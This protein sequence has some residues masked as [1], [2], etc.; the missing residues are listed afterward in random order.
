MMA[1]TNDTQSSSMNISMSKLLSGLS[2]K[3]MRKLMALAAKSGKPSG[4]PAAEKRWFDLKLCGLNKDALKR[5]YEVRLELASPMTSSHIDRKWLRYAEAFKKMP[6]KVPALFRKGIDARQLYRHLVKF[7]HEHDLPDEIIAAVVPELIHYINTGRMRPVIFVGERGCGKTTAV[8]LIMQEALH[9]PV[10][11]IKVPE[12]DRSHGLT[13]D[14]GSYK[15][16]DLGY[17]AKAQLRSNSLIVG[18]VIDEIDKVPLD[19]TSS[20][21]DDELLSVT[22]D[23]V[24][25]IEDKYL[26][27]T[28]PSLPYC[29]IF[30][31]GNDL[32]QI[33]PILADRC[34]VI[35]YP[36]A[37]PER[38]KAIMRKYVDKKLHEGTYRM[39]DLDHDMLCRSIDTLV[40]FKV[41]SL[42][43]HQEMIE[44]VLNQ[45][46][47]KAMTT[48]DDRVS[49]TPEMF[50]EA[51]QKIL[52]TASRKCGFA[53]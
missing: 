33:N 38:I 22:D 31:T 11:I 24:D 34:K 50:A 41:T 30:M 9:I 43:K 6:F 45:A 35:Q 32:K 14:S 1:E 23:S 39:I 7:C 15:S 18:Y 48:D 20:T 4:K 5:L 53:A 13:G 46:F 42:R 44:D 10:E 25:S 2:N 51:E 19:K 49:V 27:S 47:T 12:A 37:T 16:A 3:E 28:L 17:L 29:P 36:S 8:R 26:E 52:G 40:R 21:I